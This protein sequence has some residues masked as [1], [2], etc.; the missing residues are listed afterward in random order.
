VILLCP[1][2]RGHHIID[3]SI[4]IMSASVGDEPPLDCEL[5]VFCGPPSSARTCA[6]WKRRP[7]AKIIARVSS[8]DLRFFISSSLRGRDL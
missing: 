1:P 5:E 8:I 4:L 2:V 7:M 3:I 6:G